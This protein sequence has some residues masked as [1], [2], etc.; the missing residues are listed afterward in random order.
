MSWRWSLRGLDPSPCVRGLDLDTDDRKELRLSAKQL[1]FRQGPFVHPAAEQAGVRQNDI[2]I[3]VNDRP[4]EMTARQFQAYVRL[5]YKV[6][7]CITFNVLRDGKPLRISL[8]LPG[9]P[10]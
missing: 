2:I 10:K 6:G 4:L 9:R 3:G 5:E 1:A 8:K 7:Q